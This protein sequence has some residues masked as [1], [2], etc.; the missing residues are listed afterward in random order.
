MPRRGTYAGHGSG[1][2]SIPIVVVVGWVGLCQLEDVAGD[3]AESLQAAERSELLLYKKG[4]LLVFLESL[5]QEIF[6]ELLGGAR[7]QALTLFLEARG[8]VLLCNNDENRG[9]SRGNAEIRG[10]FQY[11]PRSPRHQRDLK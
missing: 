1:A 8:D 9:K 10:E 11:R 6:E 4:S 7:L 3:A 5:V 2:G